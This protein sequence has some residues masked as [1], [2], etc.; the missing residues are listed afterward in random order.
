MQESGGRR[1]K[2]SFRIDLSSIRFLTDE[3]QERLGNFVVLR[4]YVRAKRA[5]LTQYNAQFESDPRLVPNARRLTNVGTFRAY[6]VGYLRQ[7]P[8]IHQDMTL[9]V[10]QLEPTSEGLPVE[11]YMFTN[12]TAWGEY[13]DIQSDVF[14]H[15]LSIVHEFGLRVFQEP[16]GLD[17]GRLAGGQSHA[18]NAEAADADAAES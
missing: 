4:D 14:D 8:R 16:S 12:T 1:I 13:E 5:D 18:D 11:L 7:H 2:R 3:E 10:R 15:V 17:F 9:L 6:L